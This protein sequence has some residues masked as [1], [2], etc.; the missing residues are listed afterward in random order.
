MT[1]SEAVACLQHNASAAFC[2]RKGADGALRGMNRCFG[3]FPDGKPIPSDEPKQKSAAPS[4]GERSAF[5]FQNYRTVTM[6]HDSV[7]TTYCLSVGVTWET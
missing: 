7:L 6:L 4:N 5:F 1:Y 3:V 2:K